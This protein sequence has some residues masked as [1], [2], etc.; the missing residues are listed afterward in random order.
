MHL[1]R[2]VAMVGGGEGTTFGPPR[3]ASMG[4]MRRE[5]SEDPV[6]TPRMVGL[7]AAIV[8]A[9]VFIAENTRKTKIRF[10]VPQVQSP[11]WVALLAAFAVGVAA[12]WF[13]ARSR[14]KT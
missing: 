10:L 11:L 3:P 12:G 5:D 14:R 8:L 7:I 13:G 1:E 6:L 4:R 2:L 9:L